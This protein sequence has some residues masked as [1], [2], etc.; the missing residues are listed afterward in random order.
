MNMGNK[1]ILSMLIFLPLIINACAP[2]TEDPIRDIDKGPVGVIVVS[3]TSKTKIIE[4]EQEVVEIEEET[5][6][7]V[8]VEETAE[9][10]ELLSIADKKVEGI[11]YKYRGPETN[12][13]FYEFFVK[14]NN[15]KYIIDP[16]YKDPHLDD[17]AYDAVYIDNQL[18]TALGYC[19]D[20]K[21][22]I[23]GNKE[24]L[25]YD[26][27]HILTPLDW[28]NSIEFAEKLGEEL[29]GKRST[30]KLSTNNFTIWVDS[31][32]GV[33]LKV[34]SNGSVYQFQMMKFNDIKDEDVTPKG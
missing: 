29:I 25:D 9:V 28:L 34:E 4:E 26:E 17:D 22:R 14:G 15:V 6:I 24:V 23:K 20:R 27:V 7:E 16:T 1:I 2:A 31:F 32:F 10:K 18:K 33:P 8:N 21:C 12:E 5:I 3:E 30:W 13:F 11:S 19:D